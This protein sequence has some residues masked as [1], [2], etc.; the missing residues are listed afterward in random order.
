MTLSINLRPEFAINKHHKLE[1][2]SAMMDSEP[3]PVAMPLELHD[4]TAMAIKDDWT[5]EA[6]PLSAPAYSTNFPSMSPSGS[7]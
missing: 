5:L 3:F 7:Y 1:M 4:F 6:D 2:M